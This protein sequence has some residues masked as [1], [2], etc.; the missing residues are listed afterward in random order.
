M[1]QFGTQLVTG[2]RG[3]SLSGKLKLEED[4]KHYRPAREM[5]GNTFLERNKSELV[6]DKTL[7]FDKEMD[8]FYSGTKHDEEQPTHIVVPSADLCQKCIVEFG[9]PCQQ[10]CPAQV[11]EIAADPKS[12]KKALTL[13]PSNCVH[14]KTCDI[15][16]PYENVLWQ[17]PY[18]GDGPEYENM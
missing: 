7:T 4:Y 6:F 13:H 12:G 9:A 10:Y 11:F 2:G 8:I 17:T 1:L 16:D 5:A 14:C 15:K 3:L 18:G